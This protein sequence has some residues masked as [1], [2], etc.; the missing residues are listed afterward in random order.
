VINIHSWISPQIFEKIWS[1]P[2]GGA[3]GKLFHEK[4]KK[5]NGSVEGDGV[6]GGGGDLRRTMLVSGDREGGKRYYSIC[7][8]ISSTLRDPL[9]VRDK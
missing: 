4:R 1:S 3:Q 9:R 7:I 6:G 2:N 8:R 5:G